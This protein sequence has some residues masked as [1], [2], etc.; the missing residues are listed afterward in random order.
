MT[1]IVLV[2]HASTDLSGKRYSGRGDP[3][4]SADGRRE[5][6]VLARQLETRLPAGVRIVTSPSRRA[7]DTATILA[8]RLAPAVIDVDERWLETDVGEVEGLTFD[9][10]AA[11]YPE[12]ADRLVAGDAEIDWPG[13]ETGS[14]LAERVAG[15]WAALLT[16]AVPTIVVSHAGTL[17]IARALAT[18]LPA[19]DVPFPGTAEAVFLEVDGGGPPARP[20]E[21]SRR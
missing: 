1:T 20:S 4:L 17:R 9:E 16:D 8:T 12:L 14:A 5:A 10:V 6:E 18:G 21:I 2:R 3:P 15:A 7:H 13:G 11:R 19:M